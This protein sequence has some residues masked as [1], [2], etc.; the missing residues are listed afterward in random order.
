MNAAFLS[1]SV[2]G[3]LA[4]LKPV[5]GTCEVSAVLQQGRGFAELLGQEGLSPPLNPGPL[6]REDM[7]LLLL[8][9]ALGLT[10]QRAAS[11]MAEDT[12]GIL[13]GSPAAQRGWGSPGHEGT[14]LL[15]LLGAQE[16]SLACSLLHPAGF[17]F[18]NT[19]LSWGIFFHGMQVFK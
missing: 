12:G 5:S 11:L 18:R 1:N 9:K 2:K 17:N 3:L 7:A 4:T 10:S 16:C 19:V 14:L 6:T 8:S 15:L 13:P